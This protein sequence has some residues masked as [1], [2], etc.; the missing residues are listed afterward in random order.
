M[1]P[2]A[3]DQVTLVTCYPFDFIGPA[4]YRI[5]WLALPVLPV[6]SNATLAE[7]LPTPNSR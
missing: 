4:P 2:T 5:V 3:A 7:D 6:A 1:A